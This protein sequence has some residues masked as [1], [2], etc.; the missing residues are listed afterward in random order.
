M[1]TQAGNLR[2][3]RQRLV[4]QMGELL[5]K[6]TPEALAER[7]RLDTHQQQLHQQIENLEARDVR[8]LPPVGEVYEHAPNATE[9]R[10]NSPEYR[11][12][13]SHWA[14]TGDRSEFRALSDVSGSD[15]STLVPIGFQKEIATYMKFYGGLRYCARVVTS[16]TGNELQWPTLADTSNGE[17]SGTWNAGQWLPVNET[18]SEVEPTFS[19]VTLYSDLI[20]SGL[21]LVPVQLM[22]DSAFSVEAVLAEAFGRRL[23]RGTAS[24]YMNGNSLRITGLLPQLTTNPGTTGGNQVLALGANANSGNEGD[25]EI[26]SIGSEDLVNLIQAV[27]P[28]YRNSP[29]AGFIANQATWDKLRMQLDR[30]GRPL[31]NASL[32]A[33]EPDKIYGYNFFVDQSL[34]TIAASAT[35]VAV[36]GDFAQ[37]VIRDVLGMNMVRF[38]ELF[39]QSHQIGFQAYMRTFGTCLIPPAFSYLQY[40]NS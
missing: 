6:G 25:T 18:N 40:R 17:Q 33:S 16:P 31:W 26:N 34:P 22:Q 3:E 37:Y 35:G 27:D 14:R 32:A 1:S 7:A 28:A 13:F 19:N 11:K 24:A 30:Y 15:G 36:F 21:C 5:K 20:D 38:N 8:S 4:G 10:M 29:S 2:V 9:Q 12:A 39:M 23:G